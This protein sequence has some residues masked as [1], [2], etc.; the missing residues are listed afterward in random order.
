MRIFLF[1]K[2][3][4]GV[5]IYYLI[6]GSKYKEVFFFYNIFYFGIYD[7]FLLILEGG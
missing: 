6:G 5:V 3:F 4:I 7:M 1:L 2:I